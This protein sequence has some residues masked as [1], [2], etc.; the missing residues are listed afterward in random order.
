[1]KETRFRT[2]L[3]YYKINTE[4]RK[5]KGEEREKETKSLMGDGNDL[6]TNR[7]II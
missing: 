3:I 2:F 4:R 6:K 1:M 5:W 7:V